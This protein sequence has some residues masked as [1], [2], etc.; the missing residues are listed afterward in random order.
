MIG[1]AE[2]LGDGDSLAPPRRPGVLVGVV[3]GEAGGALRESSALSWCRPAGG[4]M[5]AFPSPGLEAKGSSWMPPCVVGLV[6][7]GV[8]ATEEERWVESEAGGIGDGSGGCC[9]AVAV[10][11]SPSPVKKDTV[12]LRFLRGGT[13]TTGEEGRGGGGEGGRL[14]AA[15]AAAPSGRLS[16]ASPEA[17]GKTDRCHCRQDAIKTPTDMKQTRVKKTNLSGATPLHQ[18]ENP[19]P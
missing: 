14:P 4:T 12:F 1:G 8:A 17:G 11:P 18:P 6:K 16:V 13:S 3:C 15:V 9:S 2:A 7:G 19:S 5:S 10:L